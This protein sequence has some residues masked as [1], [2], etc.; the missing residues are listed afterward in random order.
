M[1]EFYINIWW[2]PLYQS[3]DFVAHGNIQIWRIKGKIITIR[4]FHGLWKKLV[5]EILLLN[6]P[7]LSINRN[8]KEI[9]YLFTTVCKGGS[10]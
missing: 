4:S 5:R 6:H 3:G 7:L 2:Y 8:I 9:V 1:P 10:Q